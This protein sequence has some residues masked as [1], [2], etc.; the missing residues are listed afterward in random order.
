GYHAENTC[1][2]DA[3]RPL[4]KVRDAQI[5]AA[6][7]GGV[8]EH[9]QEH[10]DGRSFVDVRK[11]QQ[12][13]LRTVRQRVLDEQEAFCV[14]TATVRQARGRIK[15]WA[16]V[17]NKW[18]SVGDGL[19]GVHRRASHAFRDAAADPTVGKLHEWRKQA[20]CLRYQLQ[21]LRPLWPERMEELADEADRM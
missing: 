18:A 8:A 4:T 16:D 14:V 2:R 21:V 11:A 12:E 5:F 10:L 15:G 1:F 13:T 20:K 19:K 9:F 17:P 6:T 3:G 7:L